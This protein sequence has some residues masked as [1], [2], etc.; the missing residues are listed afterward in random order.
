MFLFSTNNT[1]A[2]SQFIFGYTPQTNKVGISPFKLVVLL[3][4]LIESVAFFY[5][6]DPLREPP[7]VKKKS[8]GLK[9]VVTCTP[10]SLPGV[11]R[12]CL[13]ASGR[14]SY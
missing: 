7:C 1:R 12:T 4:I 3:I 14:L 8:R 2:E 6:P 10:C 9:S 5:I 13:N 11:F